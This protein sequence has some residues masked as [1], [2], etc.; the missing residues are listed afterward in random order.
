METY[1][2]APGPQVEAKNAMEMQ[3]KA[4][5]AEVEAVLELSVAV[6]RMATRNWQISMPHAP[7][8]C[9]QLSICV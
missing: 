4:I 8:I 6:P 9:S 2:Q 7:Q 3:M 5:W 1:T